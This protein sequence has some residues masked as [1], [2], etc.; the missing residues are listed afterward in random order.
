MLSSQVQEFAGRAQCG[1]G[2]YVLGFMRAERCMAAA[3]GQAKNAGL[4]AQPQRLRIEKQ[5]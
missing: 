1:L 3:A 2:Q 4:R 5:L